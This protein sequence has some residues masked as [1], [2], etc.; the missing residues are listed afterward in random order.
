VCI[1]RILF[2]KGADDTVL[3]R[4]APGQNISGVVQQIDGY[5]EAG[6]RT[7]V[8]GMRPLTDH[9]YQTWRI[10]FDEANSAMQDR[11]ALKER[12]YDLIERDIV[13]VG[14]TAIEDRLQ[15]NVPET[16]ALLSQAGIKFWMCTGDKFS[17]ALTISQTC[18]LKQKHN[19]LVTVDGKDEKE[20]GS[21]LRQSIVDMTNAG[22]IG[23]VPGSGRSQAIHDGTSPQG[24]TVIIRCARGGFSYGIK[25]ESEGLR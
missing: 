10:P 17:T 14:A 6:L 11:Q 25:V 9:D 22:F 20:V 18:N 12:T 4:L 19:L 16:I 15:R 23:Q 21:C 7:L 3:P 8:L 24:Y 5:A 2:I 13:F 1:R